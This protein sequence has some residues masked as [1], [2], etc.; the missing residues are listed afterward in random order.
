MLAKVSSDTVWS[1]NRYKFLENNLARYI[2]MPKIVYT[3]GPN[4]ST[5]KNV[6]QRIISCAEFYMIVLKIFI[7]N[8]KNNLNI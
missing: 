2:T 3:P 5:C 7:I 1:I 6:F 4:N 8:L